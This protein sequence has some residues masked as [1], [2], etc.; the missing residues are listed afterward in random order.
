M[1][2]ARCPQVLLKLKEMKLCCIPETASSI[3]RAWEKRDSVVITLD[4]KSGI[5]YV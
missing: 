2:C 1:C 3:I 5:I 4:K